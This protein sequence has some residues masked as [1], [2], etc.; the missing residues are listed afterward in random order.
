MFYDCLDSFS[1]TTH[2][3]DAFCSSGPSPTQGQHK[4]PRLGKWPR[5]LGR[6]PNKAHLML[7]HTHLPTQLSLLANRQILI[8]GITRDDRTLSWPS[9]L[10]LRQA[11]KL[12]KSA[13]MWSENP[14]VERLSHYEAVQRVAAKIIIDGFP[15][16]GMPVRQRRLVLRASADFSAEYTSLETALGNGL[17]IGYEANCV[18]S[19]AT[20]AL[21][22]AT[23]HESIGARY[24]Y[25]QPSKPFAE[26]RA[27]GNF[28]GGRCL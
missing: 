25:A 18:S 27:V 2:A 28:G 22:S 11:I 20:T 16:R 13:E 1:S 24:L 17:G 7:T 21:L 4:S 19:R 3:L 14:F 6:Q 10:S 23:N 9:G 15:G 5:T 8:V 12:C 26:R